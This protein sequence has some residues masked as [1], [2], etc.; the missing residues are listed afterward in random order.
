M[1]STWKVR[2]LAQQFVEVYRSAHPGRIF[3]YSPGLAVCPGG[4][5]AAT[6]DLRATGGAAL[7]GPVWEGG[8]DHRQGKLFTSDDGGR[9]WTHRVDF[10][11]I[12]A[13]PFAAGSNL[14]VLGQ[15]GDLAI[16]RSD[17]RGQTWSRPA[18]LT[19][20]QQWHQ[21]PSNVHYANGCVYL[22][23]ERRTARRVQGWS[24]SEIAPVLMRATLGDD[25]TKRASWTF[26][27]E[28]AFC[29]TVP[30]RRLDYHG[31]PF[32]PVFYP[33]HVEIA[34]G[35]HGAPIGWLE[36]NVVQFRD[37]DHYW[38]DPQGR[39]FHLWMRAHTGGTGYAAIARVVENDDGS[40]T[41]MLETAPSG[42]KIVYLP[43]PGGQMK[44]H[45]LYDEK[46]ELY[47]LL[48]TQATDSMTRAERLAQDRY[49]LPNNE[50]RRLQLHF[51]KNCIDWCFAGLVAVGPAE[52]ASRHYA[53]MVIDGADLHVLSRSGD[54][55]AR[56]AHD[57]NI[58]T[59]HRVEDFRDLTY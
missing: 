38:Y 28:L 33:D 57:G 24:V 5:L 15:A 3:S 22:V 52:N 50:R 36:A 29:E 12:H 32:H 9:T 31:V 1:T 10:P 56:N 14:Y 30:D 39:T 19:R 2:P 54:G 27:S 25:L 17:D 46:T 49:N 4:R 20:G 48:S 11:F 6:M 23:M 51:S 26:A 53:S 55:S 35:R 45:I 8:A 47:W 13:R 58:I 44:F 7:D 18:R 43:C 34:P 21:A 16:I 40:M 42:K 37:P 59:F 41:T